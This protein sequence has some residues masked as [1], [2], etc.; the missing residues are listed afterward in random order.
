MFEIEKERIGYDSKI[1]IRLILH[2]GC[3]VVF[4]DEC[5]ILMTPKLRNGLWIMRLTPKEIET[6]AHL[7][8][9]MSN[10]EIG[11]RMGITEGSVK[12]NLNKVYGKLKIKS[13]AQLIYWCSRNGG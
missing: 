1:K 12:S 10:K 7:I 2:A 11:L 13:R 5:G 6:V 9:C 8:T 4:C 3:P